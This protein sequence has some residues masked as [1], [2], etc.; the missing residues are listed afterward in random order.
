MSDVAH[1]LF[2]NDNDESP[3]EVG[4][5]HII[6]HESN[7][8]KIQFPKAF[9]AEELQSLEQISGMF[10]GGNYE[11]VARDLN[12]RISRRV[13]VY[14]DGPP[15][16]MALVSDDDEDEEIEEKTAKPV[17]PAAPAF[18]VD[19]I[20]GMFMHSMTMQMQMMQ[21]ANEAARQA[22]AEQTKLLM[23]VMAPN[24]NQE[25]QST[26]LIKVLAPIMMQIAQMMMTRPKESGGVTVDKALDLIKVGI[27]L[28]G[29]ATEAT[30]A[31]GWQ[32]TIK[33]FMGAFVSMK[34][35]GLPPGLPAQ[36][37]PPQ[38]PP[39]HAPPQPVAP[40]RRVVNVARP[41][42]ATEPEVIEGNNV[43][44]KAAS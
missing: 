9:L 29:G 32:A 8:R 7:G 23:T 30:E 24:K 35:Q 41:A 18:A 12:N 15:K 6:R 3:P 14:L 27:D 40:R 1:P 42:S 37:F 38:V 34:E 36:Q 10:G 22:S 5:I 19:S 43:E 17:T 44:P 13:K 11:L 4:Y 16:S 25:S 2:P 26:E 21:Q 31:D 39:Q 28:K 20:M 33:Q